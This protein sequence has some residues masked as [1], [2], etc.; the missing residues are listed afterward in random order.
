M[1]SVIAYFLMLHE[2]QYLCEIRQQVKLL[3]LYC[4]VITDSGWSNVKRGNITCYVAH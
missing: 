2:W 1:V 4:I 3:L